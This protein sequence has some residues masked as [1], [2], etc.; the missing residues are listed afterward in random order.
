MTAAGPGMPRG[1]SQAHLGGVGAGL[2]RA[3]LRAVAAGELVDDHGADVVAVAGV[4]RT[5]V[6]QPDDEPGSGVGHRSS[7]PWAP[8][9]ARRAPAGR[10]RTGP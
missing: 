5:G 10:C 8:G 1:R 9:D 6:A 3:Q 2:V 4:G 7:M